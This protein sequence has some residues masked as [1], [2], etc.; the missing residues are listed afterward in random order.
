M[1]LALPTVPPR[2]RCG[3]SGAAEDGGLASVVHLQ[4][5]RG[6]ATLQPDA[7]SATGRPGTDGCGGDSRLASLGHLRRFAPICTP[8]PRAEGPK[9]SSWP[10][11]LR[12]TRMDRMGGIA[13]SG[14]EAAT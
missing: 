10:A 2:A 6:C 12:L 7:P 4:E 9:I 13:V 3:V 1:P 14:P 11:E 8:G 5:G